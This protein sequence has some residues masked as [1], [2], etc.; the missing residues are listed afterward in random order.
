MGVTIVTVTN[1]LQSVVVERTGDF[2]TWSPVFTNQVYAGHKQ[3]F[4]DP[5][6]PADHGFYRLKAMP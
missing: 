2:V 5:D 4:T 6:A 3:T 1:P